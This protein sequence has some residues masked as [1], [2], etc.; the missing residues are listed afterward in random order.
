[1][2]SIVI[3]ASRSGNTRLIAEA[4][5][6]ALGTRGSVELHPI[7]QAPRTFAAAT[8]L[9][10]VGGPTEGHGMT[11]PIIAWLDGLTAT[12][13]DGIAAAAFDTRLWWPRALSG[14]AASGIAKRLQESGARLAVREESFIVTM[15]P[16]L[17]SGE[18]E[19]AA[20]WA[21]TLAD[22]VEGRTTTSV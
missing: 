15:K 13:L 7:D 12:A 9:V 5:A 10:V 1:M 11:E 22:A 3:Y 6:N 14:S 4:I 17:E 16:A 2:K 8:D 20:V 21:A 18:L 19:R